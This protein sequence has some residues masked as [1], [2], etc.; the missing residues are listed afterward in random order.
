MQLLAPQS[1]TQHWKILKR[2]IYVIMI[3]IVIMILI[4]IVIMIMIM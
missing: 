4:M 3:M 1:T 2:N